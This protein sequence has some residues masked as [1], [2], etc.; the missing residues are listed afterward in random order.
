MTPYLPLFVALAWH[1]LV[2]LTGTD[3]QL[4]WRRLPITSSVSP[5]V[6]KD[7]G[8]GYDD[9]KRILYVYGGRGRTSGSD[10][11]IYNLTSQAW[12]QL[13][14]IGNGPAARF[15]MVSGYSAISKQFVV[16]TGELIPRAKRFANDIWSYNITTNRWT[17]LP[18]RGTVPHPRYG[19]TGGLH[20]NGTSLYVT[21]GFSRR[22]Y[23][24]TL[25]YDLSSN[26]W[27]TEFGGTNPYSATLPKPRC[28]Q[29][30]T[31]VTPDETVLYGGCLSGG[32]SGGPCPS[33]DSWAK[34]RGSTWREMKECPSARMFS[35]MAPWP[36]KTRTVVMFGGLE[37][38][39]GLISNKE[40][41]R[42][43]VDVLD[44]ASGQWKRVTT[45]GDAQ[46]GV[47]AWRVGLHLIATRNSVLLY[48]GDPQVD[49]YVWE[50]T[51]DIDL[52]P[53]AGKC[54]PHWFAWPHLHGLFMILSWGFLLQAGA[55]IARYFRDYKPPLW[56]KL[57]QAL[58]ISGVVVSTLGVV[59]VLPGTLAVPNFAHTIIGVLIL[60]WSIQQTINGIKRPHKEDPPTKTRQHWEV[61]HKCG[62]RL[63]LIL[64]LINIFL[65]LY[66][67]MAPAAV[68]IIWSVFFGL[69]VIAYAVFEYRLQHQRTA[70]PGPAKFSP[71]SVSVARTS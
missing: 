35:G 42:N 63:F 3:G 1:M 34:Q 12:R 40:G 37:K 15:S 36:M 24:D 31:M 14:Y 7:M 39:A 71:S 49:S 28:L 68:I 65:G 38:R 70:A 19:A 62:G 21:H 33:V 32:Q 61:F 2:C 4:Q 20:T 56:F 45:E 13:N 44:I 54:G 9:E 57:H 60:L 17:E 41:L 66:L 18:A 52:A 58:Q 16:A 30:G 50:L 11:W 55:F 5:P 47:P 27:Y 6:R 69:L 67:V 22:R 46:H 64:A 23:S 59:F 10:L 48:G 53:S 8:V 43:E 51:G 25:R 29:G 26:R